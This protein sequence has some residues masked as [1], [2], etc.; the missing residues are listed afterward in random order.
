MSNPMSQFM[1]GRPVPIDRLEIGLRRRHLYEVVRRAV[2]GARAADAKI[3]A[4]GGDQRLG[5]RLDQAWRR[6]GRD[7]GDLL[8]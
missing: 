6:W 7:L 2:E 3:R 5:L 4:G 8:G 1:A